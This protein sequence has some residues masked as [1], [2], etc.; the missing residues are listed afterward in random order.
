MCI[1]YW[2]HAESRHP[3]G[4]GLSHHQHLISH[5][6]DKD[7]HVPCCPKYRNDEETSKG[8]GKH[9]LQTFLFIHLGKEGMDKSAIQ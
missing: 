2:G 1:S 8:M 9:Y 4:L 7:S 5:N 3:V 6:F